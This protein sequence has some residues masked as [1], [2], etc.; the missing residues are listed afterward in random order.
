MDQKLFEDVDRYISALFNEPDEALTA[1]KNL[2]SWKI[3]QL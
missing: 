2:I 1:A 3:F